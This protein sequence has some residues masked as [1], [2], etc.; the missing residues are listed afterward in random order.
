[1]SI[2]KI[3]NGKVDLYSS[4]GYYEKTIVFSNA[5]NASWSGND[6]VI[7]Y[8]DGKVDLYS[9]SGYYIRSI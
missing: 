4:S 1:M 2:V 8:K 7:T 9:S 5:V 3:T 6:I